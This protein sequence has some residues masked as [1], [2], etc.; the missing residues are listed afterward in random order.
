MSSDAD[1]YACPSAS[2]SSSVRRMLPSPNVSCEYSN[3]F[4]ACNGVRRG[5]TPRSTTAAVN[6]LRMA[7]EVFGDAYV[8]LRRGTTVPDR[9]A[10]SPSDTITGRRNTDELRK[11]SNFSQ[12]VRFDACATPQH[13]R[14]GTADV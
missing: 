2:E 5:L 10:M 6:W 4:G 14:S 3:T 1:G 13:L 9:L 11:A 8:V 12:R 7:P